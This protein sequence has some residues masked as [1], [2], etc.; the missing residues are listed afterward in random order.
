MSRIT[1]LS[2]PP[3]VVAIVPA[4]AGSRRIPGKNL[5]PFGGR[6]LLVH[7]IEAAKG[8]YFVDA[9]YVSTESTAIAR[10]AR[11]AGAG[12]IRRPA[13]LA[14]DTAPT[15]PV[16]VHALAWLRKHG[17]DPEVLVL[18][19]PTSPLR[20]AAPVDMAVAKI[21]ETG[22]DSVVSVT[23]NP[24][25]FWEGGLDGDRFVPRRA[26]ADRP[27]TQ[28]IAPRYAEDGAIYAMRTTLLETT[29]L[30]MGGDMRAVVLSNEESVDIDTP[31]DLVL[32]EHLLARRTFD[33]D[34]RSRTLALA[35]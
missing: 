1:R 2:R 7:S 4:R 5:V 31:E 12:V 27:R 33:P 15:E 16:L 22:C 30:R 17:I 21:L 6:P 29:G 24:R 18:L 25:S 11:A 20:T 23:P 26:V 35:V 32:A 14:T 34:A 9:C 19:Q 28:D 8:A 13:R 3:R 10:V